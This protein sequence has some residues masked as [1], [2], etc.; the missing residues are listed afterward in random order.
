MVSFICSN[1]MEFFC[2]MPT[3]P[4]GGMRVP[5]QGLDQYH[6]YTV[7]IVHVV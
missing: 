5:C 1:Q 2:G 4:T 6:G 3:V 7:E